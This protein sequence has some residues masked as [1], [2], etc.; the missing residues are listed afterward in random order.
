MLVYLYLS[1]VI[2]TKVN[3]LNKDDVEQY[4]LLLFV[5]LVKLLLEG[6]SEQSDYLCHLLI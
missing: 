3:R 6:R 1:Q 2:K 4:Y 5:L